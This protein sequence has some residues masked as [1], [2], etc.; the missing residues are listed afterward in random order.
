V[1]GEKVSHFEVLD[2]LGQGGMGVVYKARDLKL[3]RLVALKFLPPS[4]AGD[5]DAERRFRKEAQTASALDHPNICTVYEIDEAEDGRPFIAMAYC[6]GETLKQRLARGPLPPDAAVAVAVQIVRGLAAA[7]EQDIVHR[8]VKPGNIALMGDGTARLLDFGLATLSTTFATRA[9][10][11]LE[12][13]TA[14]GRGAL[15]SGAG[16]VA[17]MS[18]EQARGEPFDHRTDLWSLGVVLAEMVTGQLPF[19]GGHAQAVLYAILNSEPRLAGEPV[20]PALRAVLSRALQK[21]PARRYQGASEMLADLVPLDHTAVGLPGMAAQARAAGASRRRRP[22]RVVAVVAAVGVL[23]AAALWRLVPRRAAPGAAAARRVAVLPFAY[24]GSDTLRYLGDGMVDL[25]SAKLDGAGELRAI[26]PRAIAGFA[27][28]GAL[29]PGRARA[30]AERLQARYF[31]LGGVVEVAG[32]L[33]MDARLYE[34]RSRGE[35]LAQGRASGPLTQAFELVD[36]LALG[37]LAGLDEELS[38]RGSRVAAVTTSSLPALKAYLDGESAFQRGD[39]ASSVEAFRRAV[40]LD[41]GFALAWYRLSIALEWAGT[42]QELHNE[43]A[44]QAFRHADRLTPR[45]RRL[46]EASR[47]WRQGRNREARRM[48]EAIVH[49]HPDEIEAWYQLGEVLFHRNGLYGESLTEARPAFEKVLSYEPRHFASLVHL[50]RLEARAG[51]PE[52]MNAFVQTFLSL[53]KESPARTLAIRALQAFG[54]GDA[55]GQERILQELDK[56]EGATLPIVFVDVSLYGGSL[57]GAERIARL[58]ARPDRP[59]RARAW[60]HLALAHLHV[61]HGRWSQAKTELGAASALDAWTSLEYRALL[62]CLPFL[63]VPRGELAGLREELLGLDPAVALRVGDPMVFIDAHHDLHPLLRMYLVALLSARMGDLAGAQ[64]HAAEIERQ[65]HPVGQAALAADLRRGV[66][67]QIERGRGRPQEALD[68]L[69]GLLAETKNPLESPVLSR[70]YERFTRAEL[71]LE[72]GR[73][74]EALAAFEHHVE[75]SLFEF[76]Y[77]PLTHLW[78]AEIEERLGRLQ[79]A[80]ANYRA[81]IDLWEACDPELRPLVDLARRKLDRLGP[82]A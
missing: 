46:L 51:R 16:T 39:F 78:R 19:G 25:L 69:Q 54:Q 21:N 58:L 10:A 30:L 70:A 8:D 40:G 74:A 44:E 47:V 28:E 67:A 43:A 75:S 22:L 17:Y 2:K 60:G 42:P 66:E 11:A 26:D 13:P 57:D 31:V 61:A 71:L 79:R 7:H 29:D 41:A 45:E 73:D 34:T 65:E 18:P 1:I 6:D 23:A 77:L 37:M 76:V 32:N 5:G 53:G 48:Y 62:S 20:P 35:P 38:A 59:A 72:R 27:A 24:R 64:R 49:D 63:S 50:A 4:A 81:F 15:E 36:E 80:A 12:G 55:A 52:R 82:R 3:D 9:E 56:A 68:R 14:T 33:Q